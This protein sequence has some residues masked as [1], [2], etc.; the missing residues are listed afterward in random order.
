LRPA[1]DQDAAKTNLL[2]EQQLKAESDTD[3]TAQPA[4]PVA[5]RAPASISPYEIKRYVKKHQKG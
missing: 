1:V 4:I 5:S 3:K 2:A